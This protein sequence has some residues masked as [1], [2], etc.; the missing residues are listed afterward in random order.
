MYYNF[1]SF[2][3][4]TVQVLSIRHDVL[5]QCVHMQSGINQVDKSKENIQKEFSLHNH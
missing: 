1:H 5:G 3:D 2:T 4:K